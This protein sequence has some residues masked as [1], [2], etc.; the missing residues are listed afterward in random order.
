MSAREHR[1]LKEL[2]AVAA[3]APWREKE[4]TFSGLIRAESSR[5]ARQRNAIT[6]AHASAS[7][8]GRTFQLVSV[9][10]TVGSLWIT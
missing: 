6:A 1:P 7:F 8:Q 2:L 9:R 10:G 5:Q 4:R 3:G